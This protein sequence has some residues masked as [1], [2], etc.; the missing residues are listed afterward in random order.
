MRLCLR[1]A[2][3]ER[4]NK[5]RS[6]KA[7]NCGHHSDATFFLL[8]PF[9][10]VRHSGLRAAHATAMNTTGIVRTVPDCCHF[11]LN[12]LRY[13]KC[14]NLRVPR[15]DMYRYYSPRLSHQYQCYYDVEYFGLQAAHY[16]SYG[17]RPLLFQRN[18]ML[19]I[20]VCGQLTEV[21]TD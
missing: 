20:L 3:A 7:Q 2:S 8:S 19:S 12:A 5:H 15:Q 13:V 17:H 11:N 10:D 4:N 18:E 6:N 14:F 1:T 9:W 16:Y 21:V